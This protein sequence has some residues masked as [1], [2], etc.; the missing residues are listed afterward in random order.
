MDDFKLLI[1]VPSEFEAEFLKDV[2]A[3]IK[4]IGIGMVEAVISCFE[5]FSQIKDREK[6]L[7]LLVGWAG[8]YP[9]TDLKEGDVV[10]ASKEIWV[11]FGRKFESGYQPLPEKL[12]TINSIL[13]SEHIVKFLSKKL[14]ECKIFPFIGALATVCAT[15]CELKRSTFIRKTF[16]VLAENM[17]GFGVARVAQRLGV[18]FAEIRV[19]SN[20]LEFPEKPWKIEEAGKK[21]REVVKCLHSVCLT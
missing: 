11:D 21:L 14:E 8:A 2:D 7:V 16:E 15:S 9:E 5:I 19:I 4:V 1:L 12:G 18:K 13:F 20:L 3:N 10:I 6:T 17:E